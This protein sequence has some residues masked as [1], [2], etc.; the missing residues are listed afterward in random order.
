V[1]AEPKG[2]PPQRFID[3]RIHL[4]L[5]AKPVNVRPY[6]YPQYQKGEIER[7]VEEMLKV[8]IIK[9]SHSAFSSPVLLVRKKDGTW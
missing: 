4:E 9:D 2:L 6:R 8:G 1:F 3:H 5:R 7:L